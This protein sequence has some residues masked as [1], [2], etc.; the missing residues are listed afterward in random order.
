MSLIVIAVSPCVWFSSRL[1][2]FF[3]IEG[4]VKMCPS[5][6]FWVLYIINYIWYNF[7][8][9]FQ[10]HT[11]IHCLDS[12]IFL[13]LSKLLQNLGKEAFSHAINS[14]SKVICY[15]LQSILPCFVLEIMLQCVLFTLQSDSLHLRSCY[16]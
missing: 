4:S 11:I 15:N 16:W 10:M 14:L 2:H 3:Y 6:Q 5:F 12:I 8:A 9:F 1:L 7:Y 13:Y